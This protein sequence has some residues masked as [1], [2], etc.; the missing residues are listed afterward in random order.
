MKKL[1]TL[2]LFSLLLVKVIAQDGDVNLFTGTPSV[3]V[4]I[5]NV[6]SE[7]LSHPISLVYQGGGVKVDAVAAKA[8]IGWQLNAGGMISRE[9]RG[10]PDEL[11]I[12]GSNPRKGW[13]H[14]TNHSLIGNLSFQSDNNFSDCS[15]EGAD[16]NTL[17]QLNLYDGTMMDTEPD[18]FHVNTAG[19][20]FSFVHDNNGDIK[21]I[22]YADVLIE[23]VQ[24][25]NQFISFKI[26]DSNG[27]MY[28]FTTA[29]EAGAK[30]ASLAQ[31]D[32]NLFSRDVELYQD[33][34]D[35]NVIW[36]ITSITSPAGGEIHFAYHDNNRY[37]ER[38]ERGGYYFT[39]IP[40]ESKDT[41]EYYTFKNGDEYTKRQ[42]NATHVVN[43]RPRDLKSIYSKEV[44]VEFIDAL[45]HLPVQI[46][47]KDEA[48]YYKDIMVLTPRPIL[49][50]IKVTGSTGLEIDREFIFQYGFVKNM[51]DNLDRQTHFFLKSII[52]HTN[53][54]ALPPYTFD[55]YNIN[56]DNEEAILPKPGSNRKDYF[57]YF[58]NDETFTANPEL[59]KLFVYP[60][61]TGADRYGLWPISGY[62]GPFHILEGKSGG[63]NEA[64]IMNGS[65]SRMNLPSGGH[66]SYYYEPNMFHDVS[67]GFARYGGGIRVSKVARHDGV[68]FSKD[69]I[70][71]YEYRDLT[72]HSTGQLL[73]RPQYAFT[74]SYLWDSVTQTNEYHQDMVSAGQDDALIWKKTTVRSESNLS[75]QDGP[76]V[77]YE[78]VTVFQQGQGKMVYDYIIND[79]YGSS[80]ITTTT[81]VVR[82]NDGTVT[83]DCSGFS[84][85]IK[86][87][88]Y[89]FAP[90][91]NI[92]S[93][94]G[95]LEKTSV[96]HQNGFLLSENTSIYNFLPSEHVI[97]G[98]KVERLPYRRKEF[99][100]QTGSWEESEDKFYV[101]GKY[102]ILANATPV[103]VS[104]MSTEY[105]QSNPGT[106]ISTATTREYETS[107][108]ALYLREKTLE[109]EEGKKYITEYTYSR[110]YENSKEMA[111]SDL[112][113][114][115]LKKLV[116]KR[117]LNVPVETV[118]KVVLPGTT[119]RVVGA[120]LNLF[121]YASGDHV[122]LVERKVLRTNG[123]ITNFQASNLDDIQPTA[124]FSLDPQYE[125]TSKRIE[126][127]PSNNVTTIEDRAGDHA[128]ALFDHSGNFPVCSFVG[129]K[130]S[131]VIFTNFE[132]KNTGAMHYEL[133]LDPGITTSPGRF[134]QGSNSARSYKMFSGNNS[135]NQL[136]KDTVSLAAEDYIFSFWANEFDT[137]HAATSITIT[138][139][140]TASGTTSKSITFTKPTNWEYF[141]GRIEA[142]TLTGPVDITITT[143]ED[144]RLDDI[145]IYPVSASVQHVS[146]NEKGQVMAETAQNKFV[147][148]GYDEY[149]RAQFSKDFDGNL[150]SV[151]KYSTKD[152]EGDFY[153]IKDGEYSNLA[154]TFTVLPN[155]VG[156]G[157]YYWDVLD[158]DFTLAYDPSQHDYSGIS[159]VSENSYTMTDPV[160]NKMIYVK[161]L[162]GGQ[163]YY[164]K[165]FLRM[166][167]LKVYD[168]TVDMCVSGPIK[169]DKCAALPNVNSTCNY[170]VPGTG[171]VFSIDTSNI[172]G[173][174][175]QY[176]W[177]T[178]TVGPYSG[179]TYPMQ[180]FTTSIS[181]TSSTYTITNFDQPG[182]Q[183]VWCQ[184]QLNDGTLLYTP[185][186]SVE[187][188]SSGC[189]HN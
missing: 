110:D 18:I 175:N 73:Y 66:V 133:Q 176:H 138:L 47:P 59:F 52:E 36:Q 157:T 19:L 95:I 146:Y 24:I 113:S 144:V 102:S 103:L 12:D 99:N 160:Q 84:P 71:N 35:Y 174:V 22:P 74:S 124:T 179:D 92:G 93:K 69:I 156:S 51:E 143:D 89:P 129:A 57:G 189:N 148:Y 97:V 85:L 181:N 108:G 178:S 125:S 136:F 98:L 112:M 88:S 39:S 87:N 65:L 171:T 119:E 155:N 147:S 182:L 46:V 50:K 184:V 7:G 149:G 121:K 54:H 185:L 139:T 31:Q 6:T 101:F 172:V 70:K 8:G 130:A 10:L 80:G 126:F 60:E 154:I 78:Q 141:E 135:V 118:S 79:T 38:F 162:I 81:N 159:G 131:Q 173:L 183:Y 163:V 58:N 188:Y 45:T 111:D 132:D 123:G 3:G 4:P 77:G 37:E 186:R 61:L 152:W 13:L 2:L 158:Y 91:T 114:G 76:S 63:L 165:Y 116:E 134:G 56:F 42:H 164:E 127:D 153:I 16:W 117:I 96:Y 25:S 53:G 30:T 28:N 120:S 32:P 15:D 94:R 177:K 115:A 1:L 166:S 14:N 9:L 5:W 100:D 104:S 180:Q 68:D 170:V 105:N 128:G 67:D 72:G 21:T 161:I 90:N 34:I 83:L 49:N 150:I 26:T 86:S 33:S 151:N 137:G 142:S 23:P 41:T 11:S 17:D 122:N 140:F 107:S 75:S 106:E 82:Q 187:V 29:I 40:A 64:T 168:E 55:Y 62:D 44:S 48:G 167:D 169:V 27:I 20:N 109:N 43:A 145:L